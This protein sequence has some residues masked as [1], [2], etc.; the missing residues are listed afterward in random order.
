[1]HRRAPV[2]SR[3]F[4][5]L[6]FCCHP[7]GI[8]GCCSSFRHELPCHRLVSLTVPDSCLASRA[9]QRPRISPSVPQN[10]EYDE[11][12]HPLQ[13]HAATRLVAGCVFKIASA[14]KACAGDSN[15]V[16]THFLMSLIGELTWLVPALSAASAL[17][18]I[19]ALSI[20]RALLE[21]AWRNPESRP[22]RVP[23]S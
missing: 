23:R 4:F 15:L 20:R 5:C 19:F 11:F 3:S 14:P 9:Q 1:M 16:K 17:V 2:S 7:V 12:R 6:F 13:S 22:P 18:Q 10:A 21:S 8:C